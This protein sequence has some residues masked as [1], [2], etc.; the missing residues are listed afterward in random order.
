MRPQLFGIAANMT[1]LRITAALQQGVVEDAHLGISLDGAV[2]AAL[3]RQSGSPGVVGSLI[4]GGLH[5]EEPKVWELPFAKCDGG[6][7]WHWACSHGALLDHDGNPI[8][9]TTPD[10]KNLSQRPDE[11][12]I[13]TTTV[14]IPADSGGRRGRYRPRLRPVLITPATYIRWSAVGDAEQ[15]RRILSTVHS[16]GARRGI[17][18]G[19]VLDWRVEPVTVEDMFAHVHLHGSALARPMPEPCAHHLNVPYRLTRGG[20][21]PPYFHPAVQEAVAIADNTSSPR[22]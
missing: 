7:T 5:V 20:V 21:R 22:V 10:V 6:G 15:L 4:D 14:R 16:I 11:R 19:A 17:G 18:E 3:R 8:I 1:P 13:P 9:R 12:R 2:A